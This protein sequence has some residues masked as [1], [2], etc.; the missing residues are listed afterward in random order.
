MKRMAKRNTMDGDDG[1]PEDFLDDHSPSF[2]HGL[3]A[4]ALKGS[5][6]P[7]TE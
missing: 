2:D 6:M 5:G 3:Y 1:E 4:I 7:T